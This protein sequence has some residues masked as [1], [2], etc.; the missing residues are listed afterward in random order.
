MSISAVLICFAKKKGKKI[1][2]KKKLNADIY[3]WYIAGISLF[4]F[5]E[6]LLSNKKFCSII[7]NKFE[8]KMFYYDVFI[9]LFIVNII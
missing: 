2:V 9:L 5:N 4:L 7:C 1:D 8:E 6:G 3:L